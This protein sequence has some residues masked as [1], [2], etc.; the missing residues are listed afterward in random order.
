MSNVINGEALRLAT[1]I[2]MIGG[3]ESEC[4]SSM[5]RERTVI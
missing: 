4:G 3:S 2:N 1:L 5:E